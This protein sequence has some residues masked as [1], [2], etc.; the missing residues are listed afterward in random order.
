MVLVDRNRSRRLDG[1][2]HAHPRT[3]KQALSFGSLCPLLVYADKHRT[4]LGYRRS[5]V[6]VRAKESSASCC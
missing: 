3:G 4:L 5:N 6:L 1:D 2:A